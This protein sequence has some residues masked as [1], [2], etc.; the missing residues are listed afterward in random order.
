M[1]FCPSLT[2]LQQLGITIGEMR[3]CLY[4]VAPE[5]GRVEAQGTPGGIV[6]AVG[7]IFDASGNRIADYI[8]APGGPTGGLFAKLEAV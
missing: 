4:V 3:G 6:G 5:G 8:M 2:A 7:T 1:G